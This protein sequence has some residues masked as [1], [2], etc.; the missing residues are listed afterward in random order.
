[1]TLI[2]ALVCSD[3]IVMASDGQ[4]TFFTEAG[5]MRLPTEKKIQCHK[6]R[7]LWGGSGDVGLFQKIGLVLADIT[8][9]DLKK[10]IPKLRPVIRAKVIGEQKAAAGSY[11]PIEPNKFPK[12][13]AHVL[14]AGHDDGTSWILEIDPNGTDTQLEDYGFAAVGGGAHFAYRV[15]SGFGKHPWS[16]EAGK[17]VCYK[18]IHEAIN[19]AA[20]GLGHPIQM[21]ELPKGKKPSCLSADDIK[22]VRDTYGSW[23]QVQLEELGELTAGPHPQAVTRPEPVPVPVSPAAAATTGQKSSQKS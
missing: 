16:L 13:T 22:G 23:V 21:W 19:V 14:F 6:D 4:T 20:F 11:L 12:P 7:F 1:M 18:V 2:L 17:I 3:G 15:L 5:P 10:H 8:D 9:G